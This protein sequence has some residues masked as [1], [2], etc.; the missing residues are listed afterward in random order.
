M[1]LKKAMKLVSY[2]AH[3]GL[4]RVV[5]YTHTDSEFRLETNSLFFYIVVHTV[6]GANATRGRIL[7]NRN[8]L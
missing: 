8:S 4:D 7:Q 5:E 1:P 2:H 3:Y 6:Q